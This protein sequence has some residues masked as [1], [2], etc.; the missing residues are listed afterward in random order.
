MP[1]R[2]HFYGED[3]NDKRRRLRE[4]YKNKYRN[5][6]L[7]SKKWGGID[8]K[9]ADYVMRCFWYEGKVAAFAIKHNDEEPG[10]ANFTWKSLNMYDFPEEVSLINKHD[11]SFIPSK[12]LR[13]GVD[14]A[15]GWAQTSHKPIYLTIETIID[16]IVNVE[17]VI[18]T[19]LFTHKMP[20]I[21]A[22]SEQDKKVIEDLVRQIENDD[23]VI[24][25]GF[26]ELSLLKE[27]T[28]ATPYIIDKLYQYKIT[29]ENE[30]LT[31]LGIDNDSYNNNSGYQ[32]VDQ[33]NANN[34]II[35]LSGEGMLNNMRAFCEEIKETLGFTVTVENTVQ[36]TES[37]YDAGQE[38]RGA[39]NAES[40][41]PDE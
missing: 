35:N 31:F 36:P 33:V 11:L 13:S 38:V 19:N 16:K 17:M 1:K 18:N 23:P 3:T 2:K 27:L 25:A 30:I 8:K 41:K 20:R 12:M 5:L 15:L 40:D 24:Y 32:L 39:G 37:V 22:V 29:L 34:A 7:D 28:T 10:F 4:Y 21:L 26:K 9:A 14:V 6:F